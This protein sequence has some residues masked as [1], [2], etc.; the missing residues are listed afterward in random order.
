MSS[1]TSS[2]FSRNSDVRTDRGRPLPVGRSVTR[3]INIVFSSQ[4]TRINLTRTEI[5]IHVLNGFNV[6]QIF[7][8]VFLHLCFVML[9]HSPEIIL[10]RY[11][12]VYFTTEVAGPYSRIRGIKTC[13]HNVTVRVDTFTPSG[14]DGHWTIVTPDK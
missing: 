8:N 10:W 1:F 11:P 4:S 7:L 2:I 5:Q 3:G 13:R 9:S 14:R 12:P 6:F